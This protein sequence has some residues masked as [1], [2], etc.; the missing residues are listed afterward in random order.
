MEQ[1]YLFG[2]F[3]FLIVF[4]KYY[5]INVL[6]EGETTKIWIQRKI[7]ALPHWSHNNLNLRN[8]LP[9]CSL[10]HFKRCFVAVHKGEL[11]TLWGIHST[12]HSQVAQGGC[13][14]NE[15]HKSQLPVGS[16]V[17][18][19]A[20]GVRQDLR[21]PKAPWFREPADRLKPWQKL[22]LHTASAQWGSA[23]H[24]AEPSCQIG[25]VL[26]GQFNNKPNRLV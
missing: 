7:W 15:C 3:L 5:M 25:W 11:G 24:R 12:S 23:F 20:A 26:Q 6:N 17:S 4:T 22:L 16:G 14:S 18:L 13:W 10:W 8:W 2:P 19:W 9:S 1:P 21:V